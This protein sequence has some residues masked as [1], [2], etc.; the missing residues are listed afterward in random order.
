MA[1][2]PSGRSPSAVVGD[3]DGDDDDTV[4]TSPPAG[5]TLDGAR[6]VEQREGQE[7]R[8]YRGAHLIV[9]ET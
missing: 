9:G 1:P 3:G 2:P 6:D 4:A 5:Q 7:E 8:A